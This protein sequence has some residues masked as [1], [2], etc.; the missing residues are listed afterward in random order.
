MNI[1]IT[2]GTGFL[3][4]HLTKYFIN[5]GHNLWILTRKSS[6]MN[7]LNGYE[8]RLQQV[9]YHDIN[10]IEKALTSLEIDCV[11]HTACSYGR[12][13]ENISEI[14]SVNLSFPLAVLA[15]AVK[16]NVKSFIN[17][18]TVLDKY[19]NPYSI[20]KKQFVEWGEWLAK[21]KKIQFINVLLEH[22]YGAG[23]HESKFTTYVIR[24]CLNNIKE[25]D[26]TAGEQ[27]RNFIH[28]ND[29]VSAYGILLDHL[30]DL[31]CYENISVGSG[32][33]GTI[34]NLVKLIRDLSN[35]RTKLNFGAI[36]Y[37]EGEAMLCQT[38]ISALRNFGWKPEYT[39]EAGMQKTITEEK[40]L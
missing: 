29:V 16:N 40:A 18:D 4:S 5:A 22:M 36:P 1:L 24:S 27:K 2:G 19:L 3:G 14:T 8:N 20:S 32:Y 15:W 39:L 10:D 13:G 26:L 12:A 35:S 25:L 28:I 33:A 30:D 21:Q 11:I 38:D 7:R 31:K 34:R 6:S 17:T 37:R 9:V 23:D